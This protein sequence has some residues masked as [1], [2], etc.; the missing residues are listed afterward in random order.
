MLDVSWNKWLLLTSLI[1]ALISSFTA[2]DAAGRVTSSRG[3]KPKLWLAVAGIAM[4]V[5]V[6]SMHFTG[7]LAMIFPMSMHY[8][9][10]YIV[11]SLFIV[12]AASI[13]GLSRV[14]GRRQPGWL[15]IIRGAVWLGSGIAGMH[16]IGMYSLLVQPG[17]EWHYGLVMVS[18][19]VAY[20]AS[21]VA[22][23]LAFRLQNIENGLL[24]R[25][26]QAALVM[27]TAITVVHCI[28]MQA[29]SFPQGSYVTGGGIKQTALAVWVFL[30]ALI[31]PGSS[32]LLCMI[33]SQIKTTRLARKLC[34]A[35]QELQ[36]LAMHDPLTL[37]PNRAF[38]EEQLELCIAK[39]SAGG[40]EFSLMFLDLDGFKMVNDAYGHHTGDRL[41]K[42]VA[43][44]LKNIIGPEHV[45]AR[46]GGDEFILLAP[47]TTTR[48][49]GNIA[50]LMVRAIG[51]PF[52]ICE[53]ELMV[54]LSIGI[55]RYPQ[56]GTQGREMIFNAD[57]AMY[58]TKN[59]GRNGYSIYRANMTPPGKT[60][61]EL[62]NELWR[63]LHHNELRL[64]YQPKNDAR[65]G[66][67]VGYEA[68][69][70]WQHPARG[71]LP[72]EKFL[73]VAETSGLIIPLG[74]WVINEACRQLGCWHAQGKTALSVSVN[75]S[76]LQFEQQT[77]LSVVLNALAVNNIPADKLLLEI[78]E[79]TAMRSPAETIRILAALKE[80]G[81]KVSID[82]FG[83]G[84]SSLLYLQ[85]MPASELKIDRTF[86]REMNK[87]AADTRLLAMMIELAKSMNLNI[88]AEGVETEQQQQQLTRL[89]CDT[90]QGF[91]FS[92]PV[93][94]EQLTFA[95]IPLHCNAS[96]MS[97]ACPET[98]SQ[99]VS[100]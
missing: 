75:L 84:Y 12:I 45:L 22:L 57:V 35:N 47:A 59:N 48:D 3:W 29:A 70:R 52:L 93:P 100:A 6:W 34:V 64:F 9:P 73:P 21:G 83:S 2:L 19:L 36:K 20:I 23:W 87:P 80:H 95:D 25:R 11:V 27:G 39:T 31:V 56:H 4:G 24:I 91:Y 41:L 92:R 38:L 88:V 71:L 86:V 13:A 62:K 90:L 78:S 53:Y 69:I 1:I 99:K 66:H 50:A 97:P 40:A 96:A 98:G 7:V 8:R 26:L 58:H 82:D 68:L 72:P 44:R 67:T 81:I 89:G 28:G 5:G 33:D 51:Q 85:S 63:A 55:A 61:L 10:G 30:S 32:L 17:I 65:H 77:L 18:V 79:T 42:A 76:A 46:V 49:D 14:I 15:D 54:S 37:L 16:Y 43:G 94:P 74:E 60:R